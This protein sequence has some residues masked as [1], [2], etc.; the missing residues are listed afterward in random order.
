MRNLLLFILLLVGIWWFRRS[1][2]GGDRQSSGRQSSDTQNASG[3]AP[4][5]AE[6]MLACAHCGVI[7]PVSEGLADAGRFYCSQE[8]A[9]LGPQDG[10][11]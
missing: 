8:H 6:Q 3:S 4:Q 10:R 2:G 5:S 11:S 7:V 9:R 1:L